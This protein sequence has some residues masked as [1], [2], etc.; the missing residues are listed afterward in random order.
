MYHLCSKAFGLRQRALPASSAQLFHSPGFQHNIFA[1]PGFQH[2]IFF[3][4]KFQHSGAP[5]PPLSH[6]PFHQQDSQVFSGSQYTGQHKLRQTLSEFQQARPVSRCAGGHGLRRTLSEFQ[7]GRAIAQPCAKACQR[8]AHPP[9]KLA[10]AQY[11]I[12]QQRY[13]RRRGIPIVG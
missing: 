4:P 2:N 7:Q 5:M 12:Q 3:C 1:S 6:L 11:L 13:A 8:Y 10:P 9:F